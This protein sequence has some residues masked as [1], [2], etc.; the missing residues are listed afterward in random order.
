MTQVP[1]VHLLRYTKPYQVQVWGATFWSIFRTLLY[2]APPYLI[3][4]AVD[5]VVE[6]E[7][8]LIARFGVQNPLTQLFVLSL[9][10]IATWGLESLSQYGAD[11]LWRNL[12]PF[13]MNYESILTTNLQEL[14]LAYFEDHSTG[15][16]LS[17]LNEDINQL[18]RFLNSGAQ[19][20]ISFFARVLAVGSRYCLVGNGAASLHSLGNVSVSISFGSSL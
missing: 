10:M 17:I 5:V 15:T 20:L 2:L 9:L 4:V 6:Q 12:E 11:K 3:G 18:E 7:T 14:D 16:L 13:S 1:F 8:S 19:D